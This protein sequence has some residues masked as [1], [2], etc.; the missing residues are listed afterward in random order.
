MAVIH[1]CYLSP[2]ESRGRARF[3][4]DAVVQP[5]HTQPPNR[6]HLDRVLFVHLR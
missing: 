2:M 3:E 1:R 4:V 5:R 6:D